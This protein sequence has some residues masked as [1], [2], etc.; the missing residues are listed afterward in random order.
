MQS[1]AQKLSA[2]REN[3]AGPDVIRVSKAVGDNLRA[4]ILR[5][6]ADDSFAVLELGTIFGMA[7]PAMS[8]HLKTLTDAGLLNKRREGT[9]IFYYRCTSVGH[10]FLTALFKELDKTPLTTTQTRR[11]QRVY[12][13]R[14]RRSREFFND[15]ADALAKQTELICAP[16]V[17]AD[18][19]IQAAVQQPDLQRRRALEV[20]PGDGTIL[21]ALSEHFAEVV[22][23][24]NAE[25]MLSATRQTTQPYPNVRLLEQDFFDLAATPGYNLVLA[26]MVLHHSASPTA[27]FRHAGQLLK[28]NGLLVIAELCAHDQ[29]W[30]KEACGD[31]WLGF[32]PN[33]LQQWATQG[34]F[35]LVQQQFLAQRNGFRV[36]VHTYTARQA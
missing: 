30:V 36:Q 3:T 9:S 2:A 32:T 26:S 14:L 28:A 10:P 20:G 29:E 22:G 23:V 24:D 31:V 33:Q 35:S 6:L 13:E 7:Q 17:Y 27:F 19:V 5:A 18:A 25:G 21:T 16:S 11:V 4:N 1:S 34:G 8:H 15:H 12:R